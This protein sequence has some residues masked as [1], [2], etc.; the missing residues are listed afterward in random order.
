[1]TRI[2]FA[3][4]PFDGHF[5]P[6]TG[7]ARHLKGLGH[8]V[9]WYAGPSYA[10]RLERLGIPHLPYQ[11]APEI[12]GNNIHELFPERADLKGLGWIRFEFRNLVIAN[13]GDFS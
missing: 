3:T 12:N 4:R 9:R 10:G 2:L 13:T 7:I 6:L 1:M 5:N 11:R 8:D